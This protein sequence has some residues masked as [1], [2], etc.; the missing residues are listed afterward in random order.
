MTCFSETKKKPIFLDIE[1]S[2][3]LPDSFPIEIGLAWI[4]DLD[5]GSSAKLI[6]PA[7]HWDMSTWSLDSEVVH[8]ISRRELRCKGL[9]PEEVAQWLLGRARQCRCLGRPILRS[10]LAR[11]AT[12][13][14]WQERCGPAD[15]FRRHCR[16]S[17]A[18]K[19]A[20]HLRGIGQAGHST[21]R[22]AGCRAPGLG[23]RHWHRSSD[24]FEKKGT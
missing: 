4:S 19:A 9:P 6:E 24:A 2:S 12:C 1:A 10:T 18:R 3:L 15:R 23:Q 21:P 5:I 16:D 14:D 11:C 20:M 13:D 17:W 22:R 8:G 7:P